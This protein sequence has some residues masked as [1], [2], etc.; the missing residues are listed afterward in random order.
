MV[1]KS[2][3]ALDAEN[4]RQCGR[5]KK[6]VIK[7]V[8]EERPRAGGSDQPAIQNVETAGGETDRVDRVAEALHRRAVITRP[9]PIARSPF[10]QNKII[11]KK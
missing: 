11:Y 9:A 7:V 2:Q 10:K 3:P 4:Y 5:D 6:Q 8:V 1:S